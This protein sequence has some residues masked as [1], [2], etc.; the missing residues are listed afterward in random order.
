KQKTNYTNKHMSSKSK[1]NRS[2]S[3]HKTKQERKQPKTRNFSKSMNSCTTHVN[4]CK[5][6]SKIIV[7]FC[8]GTEG[9]VPRPYLSGTT[10]LSPRPRCSSLFAEAFSRATPIIIKVSPNP[11]NIFIGS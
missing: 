7:M 4:K 9:Q 10:D 3:R 2:C 5:K 6:H 1:Q 11:L 8:R